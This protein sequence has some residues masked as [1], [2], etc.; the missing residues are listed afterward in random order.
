MK[1]ERY[2][3]DRGEREKSRERERENER[4]GS[5]GE[6]EWERERDGVRKRVRERESG[7]GAWARP[8]V[9]AKTGPV[10]KWSSPWNWTRSIYHFFV[11]PDLDS[12]KLEPWINKSSFRLT[13]SNLKRIDKASQDVQASEGVAGA[14]FQSQ[15]AAFKF[16]ATKPCKE[17]I[18]KHM[19][20]LID[21][22]TP[23]T[24]WAMSFAVVVFFT[25]CKNYSE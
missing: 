25:P 20:G 24:R 16:I 2:S 3:W 23:S 7:M 13:W 17:T 6:M 18:P 8:N 15:L 10:K 4:W 19:M 12:K 11:K 5:K 14:V 1:G 21:R 9:F 22:L